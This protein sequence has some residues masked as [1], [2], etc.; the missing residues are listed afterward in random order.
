MKTPGGARS[1]YDEVLYPVTTF[2]QTHPIRLATV[3]FLRGMQPAPVRQCRVLELGCGAGSNIIGMAFQS[4]ASEFIGLDL[5]KRPIAS[6]Q[7]FVKGLGLQNVTLHSMDICAPDTNQLGRFDYVIAHGVYS[8]VPEP[9]RERIL[10]ICREMLNP[11]GVAY[12]SYNAYP[13]N[14]LR[15]LVRG[16][17]RFHTARFEDPIDKVGQARGLLKFLADSSP[18]VDYYIAAIRAQFERTLKYTDEA[19]FHD[20]LSEVNQP[21]YF[22]EFISAAERHGLQFLGEARA[23]DLEPGKFTP[24]VK[25]RMNEL[26]GAPEV[27]QEQYKDFIRGCAFRE[28]L[29]CHR[30]AEIAPDLLVERVPKL[31]A[32]CDATLKE[33]E[34]DPSGQPTLFRRKGGLEMQATHPLI[35]AALKYLVSQWPAAVSFEALLSAARSATTGD[36][37]DEIEILANT[38][39]SAYRIGFVELRINPPELTNR[40]GERPS[41]SKLARYQLERGEWAVNQTHVLTKFPDSLSRKLVQL[42]DGTRDQETL[43]R[44]LLDF[45]QSGQ[46]A[47]L[48]NG[49]R[50]ETIA[51]AE[52]VL[53]RR[54]REGLQSLAREGMLVS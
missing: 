48:E 8:W 44:D 37:V 45:V 30:E 5:A 12:I 31:Y 16:M 6:G 49:V 20:D 26:A 39:S 29:L 2:P 13:G 25:Q 14:H 3:A 34:E 54:V 28:T 21:F 51:E 19:F 23:N 4:P 35:S 33:D 11:Q 36:L 32:S 24:Q 9:V 53:E 47:L 1:P 50:I 22:H 40:A 43:R 38:L 7:D 18:K 27:V 41:V 52:A 42:L 10:A 46:G 17:I 15:D